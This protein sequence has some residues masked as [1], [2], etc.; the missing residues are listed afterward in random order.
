MLFTN[1]NNEY[2]GRWESILS[3]NISKSNIQRKWIK[4]KV[5]MIK[6]ESDFAFLQPGFKTIT[7]NKCI[8]VKICF[9][10]EGNIYINILHAIMPH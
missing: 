9:C 7:I 1:Q 5:K 3:F 4:W 8:F 10:G 6:T 2:H